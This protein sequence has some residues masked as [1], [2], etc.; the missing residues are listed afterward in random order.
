MGGYQSEDDLAAWKARD[1]LVIA[2][3]TL[4]ETLG[5]DKVK[6]VFDGAIEEVDTAIETALTAPLP[7]FAVFEK[8]SPYSEAV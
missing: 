1:P 5:E 6:A 4:T 2:A 7:T 8:T 3:R